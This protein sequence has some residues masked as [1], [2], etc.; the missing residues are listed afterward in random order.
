MP[1]GETVSED[2]AAFRPAD[3][4]PE[5]LLRQCADLGDAPAWDRFVRCFNPVIVATVV[6]TIRRY[7]SDR[8]GLRDDLVQDVYVKFSVHHA[9][10]LRE[11]EPRHPGAIFGYLAVIAANVVHDYFKSSSGRPATPAPLPHDL[12]APDRQEWRL[13]LREMSTTC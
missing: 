3:E 12:A 9:K 4:S 1:S 13:L 11:F 10:V 8:V 5:L 6:R 7:T 2:R